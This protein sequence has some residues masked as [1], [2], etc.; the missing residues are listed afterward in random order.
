MAWVH[1]SGYEPAYDHEGLPVGVK[2]DGSE[3]A[4]SSASTPLDVVGWRSACDCGWRG[5]EFYP[6][7]SAVAPNGVDGWETGTV[8]FAEW[9]CHLRRALPELAVHDLVQDLV[10]VHERLMNACYSARLAGVTWAR[11]EAVAKRHPSVEAI[12]RTEID[13]RIAPAVAARSSAAVA[14]QPPPS[15]S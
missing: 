6:R 8:A 9:D 10:D 15:T 1:D 2:L 4:S 5:M 7:F 13:E 14:Q 12:R 11:I 3:T